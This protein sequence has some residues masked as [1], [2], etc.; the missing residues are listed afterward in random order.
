MAGRGDLGQPLLGGDV[1]FSL[2]H[3]QTT[4]AE[5]AFV[6]SK[7]IVSQAATV[8]GMALTDD[9]T[10]LVEVKAVDGNYPLYGAMV[11]EGGM[12]LAEAIATKDGVAG[13]A[14]DPLL[15]GRL[16]LK[17]GDTMRFDIAGQPV[18]AGVKYVITKWFRARGIGPMFRED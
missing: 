13:A 4:D 6:K 1:E 7:G 5:L 12:P 11:L 17:L 18:E 10:A 14:A 9:S 15:L 2:I 16:G 3:R 8:R